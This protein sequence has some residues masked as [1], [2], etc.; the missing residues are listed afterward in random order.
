LERS[1]GDPPITVSCDLREENASTGEPEEDSDMYASNIAAACLAA[2]A[3]TRPQADLTDQQQKR[4]RLQMN[5]NNAQRNR[6][7]KR[8]MIDMLQTE[9]TQLTTSNEK[10]QDENEVLN[11]HI[12]EL[13][14]NL[15]NKSKQKKAHT[16][17]SVAPST[18]IDPS[19]PSTMEGFNTSIQPSSTPGSLLYREGIVDALARDILLQ[20]QLL[21]SRLDQTASRGGAG[22]SASLLEVQERFRKNGG[23]GQGCFFPRQGIKT[24]G[25]SIQDRG[26]ALSIPNSALDFR[27][28]Q[29]RHLG[30]PT[31]GPVHAISGAPAALAIIPRETC[32]TVP[33]FSLFTPVSTASPQADTLDKGKRPISPLE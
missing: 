12:D 14:K 31:Q 29:G 28:G 3:L 33:D 16:P 30:F 21:A 32:A 10:L 7:R 19:R 18:S 25:L 20:E 23:G 8:I 15:E 11:K 17:K 2:N 24:N 4:R 5:R 22:I 6:D 1:E 27:Y 9:K 13:K 26:P